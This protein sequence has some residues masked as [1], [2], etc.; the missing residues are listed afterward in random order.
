MTV[1]ALLDGVCLIIKVHVGPGLHA[2]MYTCRR[3]F[4]LQQRGPVARLSEL[5]PLQS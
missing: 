2:S 5:P 1:S 4:H 3:E